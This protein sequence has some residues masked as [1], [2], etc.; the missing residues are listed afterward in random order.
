MTISDQLMNDVIS[1]TS[2]CKIIWMETLAELT[3]LQYQGISRK[4][5]QFFNAAWKTFE[6]RA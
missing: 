4:P 2:K 5:H 3:F 1:T 6:T